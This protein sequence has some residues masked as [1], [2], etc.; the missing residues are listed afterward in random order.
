MDTRALR[1]SCTSALLCELTRRHTDGPPLLRAHTGAGA[2]RRGGASG[3]GA[4]G[5]AAHATRRGGAGLRHRGQAQESPPRPRQAP[6][7][8]APRVD[9][10]GG[11]ARA[12]RAGE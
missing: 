2:R 8:S 12:H 7:Q 3:D 9:T 5:E 6:V 1:A 10:G 11:G 4:A